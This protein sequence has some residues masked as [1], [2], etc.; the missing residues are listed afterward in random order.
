LK[1]FLRCLLVCVP[2]ALAAT[3]GTAG[4]ATQ[5]AYPIP[6]TVTLNGTTATVT[7]SVVAGC[8]NVQVSAVSIVHAANPA[9]DF[10]FDSA[11]G[12]FNPGN[13][14]LQVQVKCGTNSEVDLILGP[15]ALYPPLPLDLNAVPVH[16]DCA[17]PGT[18]TQGYW[19]NH[20]DK[21][22]V[23]S[24]QLGA[25]TVTE[26]QAI[27]I[28]NTPAKG[29][30]TIILAYQLIAAELNVALGNNSSCVSST[31]SAANALLTTYPVGS[32]LD[33]SSAAGQIATSLANTLDQYNNGLLC[34]PHQN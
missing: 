25:G 23:S 32:N 17:G 10:I 16:V 11:T 27:A 14:S 30:A 1:S 28:L 20:P 7:F 4:A 34:A 18:L 13:W 24:V 15:P 26:A 19:K 2:L 8:S 3:V 21:W 29:D 5:C 33:P 12:F 9:N 31:I 22:P 6:P